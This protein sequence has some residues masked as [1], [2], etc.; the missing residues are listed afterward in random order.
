MLAHSVFPGGSFGNGA[1]MRVAPVGMMFA[2][3]PDFLEE[4][5]RLS[6]LVTHTHPWAIEGAR[7]IAVAIAHVLRE[8]QYQR[9]RLFEDLISHAR[10]DEFLWQLKTA[11]HMRP[12][13][14]VALFGNSIE[15]HRSVVTALAC[16]AAEPDSY[17]DTIAH[18]IS[19]GNDTDTLAAMAGAISG[20]ALG[21]NAIPDHLLSRLEDGIKGRSYLD[22]LARQLYELSM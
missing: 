9:G 16:F 14:S 8:P 4:Q 13:E 19:L 17:S 12:D 5:V 15:A 6:A 7:L 22:Q 18:A 10:E 2:H 21:I 11:A 1:A 20:A 3:K